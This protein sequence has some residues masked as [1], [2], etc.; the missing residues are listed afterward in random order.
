M[1]FRSD[2][3]RAIFEVNHPEFFAAS[4]SYRRL[5]LVLDEEHTEMI[6]TLLV[7][8]VRLKESVSR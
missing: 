1:V 2:D 5:Y 4:P 3:E 8:S 6:D 7:E